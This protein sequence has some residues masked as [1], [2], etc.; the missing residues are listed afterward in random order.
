MAEFIKV[1]VENYIATVVMDR[2]PVNAQNHAFREAMIGV[3]DSL[4]DR[5][6]VRVAILTG[7]G[8]MFSAG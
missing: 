8:K 4:T 7:T 5:E 6:D 3:F 1:T 2:P